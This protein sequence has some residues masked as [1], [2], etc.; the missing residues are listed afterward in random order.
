MGLCSWHSGIEDSSKPCNGCWPVTLLIQSIWMSGAG[1]G[2]A[3][4]VDTALGAVAGAPVQEDRF[5]DTC[6]IKPG[7]VAHACNPSCLGGPGR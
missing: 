3:S 7:L 4:K 1:P 5:R 6:E 2:I